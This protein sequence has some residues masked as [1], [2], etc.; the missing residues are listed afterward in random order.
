[1][2]SIPVSL[3]VGYYKGT[4]GDDGFR[5]GLESLRHGANLY[6]GKSNEKGNLIG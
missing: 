1:M 3:V 5:V 6:S 4:I 2:E